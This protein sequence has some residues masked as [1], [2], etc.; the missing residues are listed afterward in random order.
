MLPTEKVVVPMIFP[1]IGRVQWRDT[2]NQRRGSYRHT[3][4]DLR[5]PKMTPIVA[6]FA[7]VLGFKEFSFWIVGDNGW[8]CLATHLN[9]DTPGTSDDSG[10]WDTM[11]AANLRR[12]Q[13]VVAGQLIG[14]IGD[15]GNATGPHLH[16]EI[17]GP[18][19]IR[20]PLASLKNAQVIRR[21]RL[22]LEDPD[23]VPSPGQQR[24][25]ICWRAIDRSSRMLKGMI[26]SRQRHGEDPVVE[27]RPSPAWIK[28]QLAALNEGPGWDE[29][30]AVSQD[31]AFRVYVI[32]GAE[33]WEVVR[34]RL[35]KKLEE[36]AAPTG[37]GA[38][39]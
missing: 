20:N 1:V 32:R 29:I 33:G 13:R 7:G 34:F 28:V 31:Q 36:P 4:Q 2:Y 25:D 12:G 27:L 22:P 19:G 11:F 38:S 3:G 37:S 39:R 8:R 24:W 18:N 5:A 17:H 26:V 35:P 15:S 9:N 21:A 30:G 16:F 10:G 6:P 23:D 14:W